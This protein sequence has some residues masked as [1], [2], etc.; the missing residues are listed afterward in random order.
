MNINKKQST[1][2]IE[3]FINNVAMYGWMIL[4]W[5]YG[6]EMISYD[7]K[8]KHFVLINDLNIPL[9]VWWIVPW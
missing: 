8:W 6:F 3:L 2:V 7:F 9:C 1:N 4:T 5:F